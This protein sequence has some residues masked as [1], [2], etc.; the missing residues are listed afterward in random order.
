ML[1]HEQLVAAGLRVGFSDAL[2]L[3]PILAGYR[4]NENL[5]F[6]KDG[7]WTA[8]AT[9]FVAPPVADVILRVSGQDHP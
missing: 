3:P 9:R 5:F 6:P 4:G 2:A 1:P 8:A 7:H